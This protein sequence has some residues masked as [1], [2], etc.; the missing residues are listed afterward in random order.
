VY[1][2]QAIADEVAHDVELIGGCDVDGRGCQHAVGDG[3]VQEAQGHPVQPHEDP[4]CGVV[5]RHVD[6]RRGQLDLVDQGRLR[7]PG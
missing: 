7:H 1:V 5:G 6:G 2:G 4:R 3:E